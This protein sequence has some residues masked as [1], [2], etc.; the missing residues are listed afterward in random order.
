MLKSRQEFLRRQYNIECNFSRNKSARTIEIS[1]D[2][3]IVDCENVNDKALV[4]AG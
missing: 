2:V 1:R 3:I 4:L